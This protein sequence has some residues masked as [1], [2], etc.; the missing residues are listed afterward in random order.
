M[1]RATRR[2]RPRRR[3][4]QGE[5]GGR[6]A[7]LD[8]RMAC[9]RHARPAP[10]RRCAQRP[11]DAGAAAPRRMRPGGWREGVGGGG[12]RA[13]IASSGSRIPVTTMCRPCTRPSGMRNAGQG[14]RRAAFYA[15]DYAVL[16]RRESQ[17]KSARLGRPDPLHSMDSANAC[18][19][20]GRRF[21]SGRIRPLFTC[22]RRMPL[23]R[24]LAVPARP[25][26]EPRA[27]A[28]PHRAASRAVQVRRPV[29]V[30][31]GSC[32]TA[33]HKRREWPRVITHAG[34]LQYRPA[35]G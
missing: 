6:G 4:R 16:Y 35:R 20:L 26:H 25:Q 14:R 32:V 22:P 5:G 21:E 10:A 28:P 7:W 23:P 31:P 27:S 29:V 24:L 34:G 33:L 19:A 12:A 1:G 11:L 13:A 8:G 15:A 30:A 2:T 9:P 18:G 17:I 3:S